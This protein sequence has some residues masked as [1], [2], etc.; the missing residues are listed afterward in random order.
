MTNNPQSHPD[1]QSIHKGG[2]MAQLKNHIVA[3]TLIVV[4]TCGTIGISAA[5][6]FAPDRVKPSTVLGFKKL[7]SDQSTSDKTVVVDESQTDDIDTG[8]NWTG[9]ITLRPKTHQ[10]FE[11]F[12]NTEDYVLDANNNPIGCGVYGLVSYIEKTNSDDYIGDMSIVNYNLKTP[13]LSAEYKQNQLDNFMGVEDIIY[14][15]RE[16]PTVRDVALISDNPV[17]NPVVPAFSGSCSGYFSGK[18]YDLSDE[19]GFAMTDKTRVFLAAEGQSEILTPVVV[20]LAK[21][22]DNLIRIKQNVYQVLGETKRKQIEN[23]CVMSTGADSIAQCHI[24]EFSKPEFQNI[25]QDMVSMLY[26]R[27]AL[28]TNREQ[29]SMSIDRD[30]TDTDSASVTTYTNPN[31]PKLKIVY[32]QDWQ[33]N[34]SKGQE[35]IR[36]LESLEIT[37]SKNNTNLNFMLYP[38]SMMGCGIGLG[39]PQSTKTAEF[40]NGINKIILSDKSL[41][42]ESTSTNYANIK[43]TVMYIKDEPSA[44]IMCSDISITSSLKSKDFANLPGN[45]DYTDFLL[46]Q[47]TID[48]RLQINSGDYTTSPGDYSKTV[49]ENN[50]LIAE[51]DQIIATSTFE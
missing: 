38:A 21:K 9:V 18:V 16:Y 27:Y 22:G 25:A 10:R 50:P 7:S 35:L 5:E 41:D 42:T 20:I 33:L 15:R 11:K 31:F 23:T 34:T 46:N 48:Y 3:V 47:D 44:A 36:G 39:Q 43:D 6:I 14:G 8:A 4:I 40:S 2:L 1:S 12:E 37:L 13:D 24:D 49:K 45:E 32:P 19:G 30:K 28:E 29:L 17:G 51:I 26:Q